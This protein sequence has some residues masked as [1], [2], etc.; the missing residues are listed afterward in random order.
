[1]VGG[2]SRSYSLGAGVGVEVFYNKNGAAIGVSLMTP[3][4]SVS[5]SDGHKIGAP[6]S[7]THNAKQKTKP[8]TGASR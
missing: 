7:L 4:A 2:W 3:G 1:M 8:K 5:K 6:R